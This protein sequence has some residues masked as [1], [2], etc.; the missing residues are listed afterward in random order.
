[1]RKG[2][3][4]KRRRP[5]SPYFGDISAPGTV[6]AEEKRPRAPGRPP[7]GV[8]LEAGNTVRDRT[9]GPVYDL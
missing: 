4:E 2:R 5:G 3:E 7:E 1:M 6:E 8:D 9:A